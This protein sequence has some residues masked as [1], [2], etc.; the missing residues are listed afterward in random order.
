MIDNKNDLREWYQSDE[1][2]AESWRADV[3]K[4]RKNRAPLEI[5]STYRKLGLYEASL[6]TSDLCFDQYEQARLHFAEAGAFM[7]AYLH[8][9]MKDHREGRPRG[10]WGPYLRR[11]ENGLQFATLSSNTNLETRLV[12]LVRHYQEDD[13]NKPHFQYWR[14]RTHT[15]A[16][17]VDEDLDQARTHLDEA[18]TLADHDAVDEC[19]DRPLRRLYEGLIDGNEVLITAAATDL[20]AIREDLFE[21]PPSKCLDLI[22]LPAVAGLALA[23]RRGL[24]VCVDSDAVPPVVCEHDWSHREHELSDLARKTLA[25]ID[26]HELPNS[27]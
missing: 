14:H 21:P 26:D 22:S 6:G 9:L 2:F 17:I 20:A 13:A 12:E 7:A 10:D 23:R 5:Q 11:A 1:F 4:E 19:D 25:D 15:L 16:A 3:K 18:T 8:V 27:D 24:D